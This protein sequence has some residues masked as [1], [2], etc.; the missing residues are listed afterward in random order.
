MALLPAEMMY[1]FA[2]MICAGA[3]AG[4]VAGLFGIGGGFVIVP[5]LLFVFEYMDIDA[6]VA[7]YAAIGTSLATIIFTSL[8]AL[9]THSKHNAVDFKIIKD[10]APWLVLGVVLGLSLAS[11]APP[12]LLVGVFGAGVLILSLHFLFPNWLSQKKLSNDMPKGKN[13]AFLATFLGGFSALLGIGGGTIAVLTMTLSGRTIHQSVATASGFGVLIAIPG[14]I[15]FII[16]GLDS[17]GLPTGS[18]GYV[19]LM[20]WLGISLASLVTAPIGARLAHRLDPVILKRAFGIYLV[21][22]GL[23]MLQKAF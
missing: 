4:L 12:L 2:V 22:T 7:V 14:T 10:W 11:D 1:L 19:N 9:R 15:G 16:I 21:F 3:V 20:G 17:S 6:G 5:V 8:R 23:L 13:K 18:F